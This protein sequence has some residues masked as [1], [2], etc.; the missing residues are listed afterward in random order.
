MSDLKEKIAYLQGLAEGLDL[1]KSTKEGKMFTA[2]IDVLEEIIEEVEE[3]AEVQD[4]LGEY[5]E[6]IDEDM[7]DLETEVYG[8][9]EY[10]D[11]N[12]EEF[13]DWED[14]EGNYVE[15]ECPQ[16]HDIVRFES[17]ILSDEDVIE[18][19][20]PNCDH[21]VYV[22]EDELQMETEEEKE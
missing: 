15:I 7:G 18:V 9:D 3:L 8:E 6:A 1:D 5:I 22:N 14:E 4:E 20:C 10:P 2:I 13:G 21:V 12:E 16:C 11:E 19:T 17:S